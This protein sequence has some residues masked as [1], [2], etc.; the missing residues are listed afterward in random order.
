MSKACIDRSDSLIFQH[1]RR[2]RVI[3]FTWSGNELQ[4]TRTESETF[5]RSIMTA[6]DS[7]KCRCANLGMTGQVQASSGP[8]GWFQNPGVCYP[9]YQRFFS[10]AA[11]I[12]L[13]KSLAPR[14]GVCLQAVPSFLPHPVPALL[15]AP[16]FARPLTLVPR[17]LLLNRTE[18][19]ATQAKSV[20]ARA[21]R[22]METRN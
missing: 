21:M 11:G 9:G 5:Y 15:L 14:V 7:I 3:G 13:E 8:S 19:L 22:A 17:S 20:Q 4:R 1:K 12:A 16:F 6:V 18:T 10:R 2:P